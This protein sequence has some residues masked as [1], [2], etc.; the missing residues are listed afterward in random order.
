[1]GMVEISPYKRARH[2]GPQRLWLSRRNR[3]H[4]RSE[5]A[6]INS[7]ETATGMVEISPH[8]RARRG[9]V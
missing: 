8:K 1:M 2:G 4:V 6:V 7:A 3:E 5:F 9:G